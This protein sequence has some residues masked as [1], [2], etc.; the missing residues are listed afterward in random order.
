[1]G[2][3]IIV[4]VIEFGKFDVNKLVGKG[5]EMI[6]AAELSVEQWM[7]RVMK[8]YVQLVLPLKFNT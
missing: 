3:S 1:M 7:V 2:C 5:P 6:D 4:W 8:T